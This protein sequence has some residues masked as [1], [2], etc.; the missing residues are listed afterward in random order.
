MENHNKTGIRRL[1]SS[2]REKFQSFPFND[3]DFLYMDNRLVI[4]Q[5]LRPMIMCSLHYSIP[6]RDSMLSM[7]ADIWWPRIHREVVDQSR[8]C[9]QCL[10][11]GKNLKCMISQNQVNQAK[12]R[13]SLR[14]RRFVSKREKGKKYLLVSI[15]H[16]S[17]WPM[18]KHFYT[19]QQRKTSKSFKTLN[20]P[21]RGT[22]ENKN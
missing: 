1:P 17:G 3:K 2:W 16:D 14:L 21:I 7:I 15:E 11:S 20:S 18:A 10:Q 12:K 13:V 9:D 4:P 5:S 22:A 6:G 8:L 19:A